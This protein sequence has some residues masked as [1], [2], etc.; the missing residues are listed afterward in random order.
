MRILPRRT[1]PPF[2]KVERRHSPSKVRHRDGHRAY[3]SCLRWEFGF[4]CAFCLLH[5]SDF[6]EHGAEGLGLLGVE[7]FSP[8]STDPARAGD[9]ENCFYC[10]RLCNGVRARIPITGDD[11]CRLLNPCGEIWADHFQVEDDDRLQPRQNDLDA[12]YTAFIY[13]LNEPCKV[14]MRRARRERI[15]EAQELLSGGPAIVAL[16]LKTSECAVSA[17]ESEALLAAAKS[18]EQQML[19][20]RRA[21]ERHAAV[22]PDAV[23]ACRC[24]EISCC[25][26][27]LWLEAQTWDLPPESC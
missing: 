13:D 7:H 18:F 8:V 11:G 6:A 22:P 12:L 10:C 15:D 20:A 1:L 21:L 16:L 26:L 19:R 5:E 25:A 4:S 27:P 24:G 9:Y 17:G 3:R 14:N 23:N 2:V